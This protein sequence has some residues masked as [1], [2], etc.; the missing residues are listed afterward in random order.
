MKVVGTNIEH[1]VEEIE[2]DLPTQ[3][4]CR[5]ISRTSLTDVTECTYNDTAHL[6]VAG[7]TST[8]KPNTTELDEKVRARRQ[9]YT[10]GTNRF[11]AQVEKLR[12]F[13]SSKLNH[14]I[15]SAPWAKKSTDKSFAQF[16]LLSTLPEDILSTKKGLASIGRL[17]R[18]TFYTPVH[19]VDRYPISP[20]TSKSIVTPEEVASICFHSGV[21]FRFVPRCAKD[22]AMK[23]GLLGKDADR[24]QL[25]TVR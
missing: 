21:K 24:Y 17:S 11:S 16:F 19:V 9:K 8:S 2:I 15:V 14:M 13:Q 25:H 1:E 4:E 7:W 23:K 20:Q 6:D 3:L 5:R 22:L 18:S 12:N 10:L